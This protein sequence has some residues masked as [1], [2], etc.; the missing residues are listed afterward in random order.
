MKHLN[1][2]FI[3][4]VF[5]GP[6]QSAAA[7][8]CSNPDNVIKTDGECWNS[9][10]TGEKQQIIKGIWTGIEIAKKDARFSGE[11]VS[12]FFHMEHSRSAP[13]TTI[14]DHIK[15]ID[16]LYSYPVNRNIEWSNAFIISS[17]NSRDDDSNDRINMVRFLRENK[18]IPT[19]GVLVEIISPDSIKIENDNNYY[20]VRLQ[21]IYAPKNQEYY[22]KAMNVMSSLKTA[23]WNDACNN[24]NKNASV[25]LVYGPEFFDENNDLVAEVK[26]IGR[27]FCVSGKTLKLSDLWGGD[28]SEYSINSLLLR[29]GL[30]T[31]RASSDAAWSREKKFSERLLKYSAD[32]AMKKNFYLHGAEKSPEIE[33]VSELLKQGQRH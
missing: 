17:I 30:A 5:F 7:Q 12:Y 20:V 15:Y 13:K 24:K 26:L 16:K 14:G 27:N 2:F 11:G 18:E 8:Q 21:G 6:F 32:S 29:N 3:A 4:A 9:L 25:K 28:F 23:N 22:A 31:F 33:Y 10:S 19:S 1:L